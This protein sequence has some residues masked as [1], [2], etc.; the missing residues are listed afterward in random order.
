M[1][2]REEAYIAVTEVDEI[3]AIAEAVSKRG[4]PFTVEEMHAFKL[5][6]VYGKRSG[7]QECMREIEGNT[8]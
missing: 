5:G 1:N 2:A 6:F 8:P 4:L 7:V 3:K